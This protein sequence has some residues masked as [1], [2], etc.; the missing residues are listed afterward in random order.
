MYLN[1]FIDFWNPSPPAA[2]GLKANAPQPSTFHLGSGCSSSLTRLLTEHH[3]RGS[4]GW[5]SSPHGGNL[6]NSYVVQ[7]R[8]RGGT[9]QQV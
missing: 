5:S 4:T 1:R 8:G 6:D 7:L 9:H 3:R 2:Y